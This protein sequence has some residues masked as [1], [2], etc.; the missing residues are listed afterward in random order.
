MPRKRFWV[1]GLFVAFI[2]CIFNSRF[3]TICP[4]S[5]GACFGDTS[6]FGWDALGHPRIG[7]RHHDLLG[8]DIDRGHGLGHLSFPVRDT[9]KIN[10]S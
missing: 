5:G 7:W 3:V 8:A 2:H 4:D 10:S 6:W 1:P 9:Q